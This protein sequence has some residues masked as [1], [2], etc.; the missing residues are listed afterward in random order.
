MS[1]ELNRGRPEFKNAH[2]AQ[3]AQG[4]SFS[5]TTS[6]YSITTAIVSLVLSFSASVFHSQPHLRFKRTY[7]NYFSAAS[8]CLRRDDTKGETSLNKE[9]SEEEEETREEES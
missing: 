9:K 3:N 6:V 1:L 2:T 8:A 4:A 7:V 5:C